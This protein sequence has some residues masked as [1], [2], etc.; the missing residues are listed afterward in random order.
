MNSE[1][2]V[3]DAPANSSQ[4]E[5]NYPT[6]AGI[7]ENAAPR[8]SVHPQGPVGEAVSAARRSWL[9][10]VLPKIRSGWWEGR[11]SLCAPTAARTRARHGPVS[12]RQELAPSTRSLKN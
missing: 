9:R 8:P 11:G 7:G 4:V 5:R 6:G 1:H 10:P 2:V 3:A 12:G